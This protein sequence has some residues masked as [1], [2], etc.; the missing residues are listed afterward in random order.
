MFFT[1]GWIMSE[2][3]IKPR[4]PIDNSSLKEGDITIDYFTNTVSVFG[5]GEP[6]S[7][8][9]TFELIDKTKNSLSVSNETEWEC[10]YYTNKNDEVLSI[11]NSFIEEIAEAKRLKGCFKRYINV[12]GTKTIY[13][14]HP[15]LIEAVANQLKLTVNHITL[16]VAMGRWYN[17]IID[18]SDEE[19]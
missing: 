10:L 18:C 4:P 15:T 12:K 14:Y 8:L 16:E 5:K 11:S 7:L 1:E 13:F 2:M 9:P 3:K 17:N 6:C 19:S